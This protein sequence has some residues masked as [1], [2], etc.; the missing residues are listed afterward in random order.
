MMKNTMFLM[1]GLMVS[2]ATT[3]LSVGEQERG[4]L[5]SLRELG[6][7]F[8]TVPMIR[9]NVDMFIGIFELN[10]K[11][12]EAKLQVADK[13]VKSS[14][15]KNTALTGAA[16]VFRALLLQFGYMLHGSFDKTKPY[17]VMAEGLSR[18][19]IYSVTSSI[20]MSH[21]WTAVNM[22]DVFKER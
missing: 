14:L 10:Y 2:V 6:Q 12:L 15:V 18:Q 9:Q 4:I 7:D 21:V 3:A 8:T 11:L 19:M 13:K 22:Y 1:A 20:L 5:Y 16:I 17:M